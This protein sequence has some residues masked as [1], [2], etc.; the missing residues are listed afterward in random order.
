MAPLPW[1]AQRSGQQSLKRGTLAVSRLHISSLAPSHP[2]P[3]PQCGMPRFKPNHNDVG[4]CFGYSSHLSK[5]EPR[6]LSGF[7]DSHTDR[8]CLHGFRDAGTSGLKTTFVQTFWFQHGGGC[9]RCCIQGAGQPLKP[10][11]GLS[12]SQRKNHEPE[13]PKRCL[14][15]AASEATG[16]SP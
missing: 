1:R 7:R 2:K 12:G 4:R 10:K 14:L 9:F 16:S 5:L 6:S 8:D 11:P 13:G 15:G 3:R